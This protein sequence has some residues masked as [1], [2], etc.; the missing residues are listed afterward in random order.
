MISSALIKSM[1]HGLVFFHFEPQ[2]LGMRNISRVDDRL[3]CSLGLLSSKVELVHVLSQ[4]SQLLLDALLYML[5]E[6]GNRLIV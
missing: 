6:F 3:W 4:L 1:A 5:V 2:G